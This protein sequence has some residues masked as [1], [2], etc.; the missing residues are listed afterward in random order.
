MKVI[1][2]IAALLAATPALAHGLNVF[3]SVEG[4]QIVIEARFANGRAALGAKVQV[5]DG[6]DILLVTATTSGEE[7]R[8]PLVGQDTGVRIVVDAGDGHSDYW[9]MTPADLV[10]Q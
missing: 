4:E 8:V 10:A 1:A 9:I 5:F 3:A 6:N 7:T 2:M